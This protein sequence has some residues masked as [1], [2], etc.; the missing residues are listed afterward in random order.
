MGHEVIRR[1]AMPVLFPVGREDDI[2]GVEFDDLLPAYLHEAA[3]FGDV[4][5]LPALVGVPGTSVGTAKLRV[6]SQIWPALV[7][8][9]RAST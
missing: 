4:Q 7:L 6:N 1:G 9:R 2:S 3:A 8:R 5:R